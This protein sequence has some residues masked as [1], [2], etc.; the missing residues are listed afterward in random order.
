MNEQCLAIIIVMSWFPV[1]LVIALIKDGTW[2]PKKTWIKIKQ[3][4]CK[5]DYVMSNFYS[6]MGST[7][8]KCKKC[9]KVVEIP[10]EYN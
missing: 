4:L 7:S 2:K 1:M 8:K 5:H 6:L 3:K 10:V 9:G